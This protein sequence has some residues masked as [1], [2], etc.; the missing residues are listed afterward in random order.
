MGGGVLIGGS[1][2][3]EVGSGGGVRV[4]S[5][6]GVGVGSGGGG[7]VWGRGI[8]TLLKISTAFEK[9]VLIQETLIGILTLALS[10]SSEFVDDSTEKNV[11]GS[12]SSGW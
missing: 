12:R 10:A 6:G 7:G 5:G 11:G 1:G 4:G 9:T 8:S 2:G 3:E